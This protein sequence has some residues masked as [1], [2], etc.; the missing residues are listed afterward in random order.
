MTGAEQIRQSLLVL[1]SEIERLDS[2]GLRFAASL[3]RIAE[4]ELR[5]RLHNLSDDEIDVLSFA[6][7]AVER[8]RHAHKSRVLKRGTV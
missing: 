4:V 8:E 7:G 1:R 5:V 6:A 2:I 3:V